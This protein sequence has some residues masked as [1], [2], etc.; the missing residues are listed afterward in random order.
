MRLELRCCPLH[1]P[2]RDFLAIAKIVFLFIKF[3][4]NGVLAAIRQC[5]QKVSFS[6]MN[7]GYLNLTITVYSSDMVLVDCVVQL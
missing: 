4:K 1:D 7:G 5:R 2:E 6:R 3:T